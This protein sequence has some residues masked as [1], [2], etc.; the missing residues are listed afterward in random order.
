MPRTEANA[1][2]VTAPAT[3]GRSVAAVAEE[4]VAV[5]GVLP[6]AAVGS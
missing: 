3:D 1:E 5:V 4:V 2:A 6:A